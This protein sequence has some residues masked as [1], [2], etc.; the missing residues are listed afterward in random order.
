MWDV[1]TTHNHV[2]P[3]NIDHSSSK[4]PEDMI[5]NIKSQLHIILKSDDPKTKLLQRVFKQIEN[6]NGKI[7]SV[8][9]LSWGL[10]NIV[11]SIKTATD[12]FVLKIWEELC[13]EKQ[14][15]WNTKS[16]ALF[17]KIYSTFH[18][19]NQDT[20]LMER[21]PGINGKEAAN[22]ITNWIDIWVQMGT[23]LHQLHKNTIPEK[24]LEKKVVI[25]SLI[26]YVT[27]GNKQSDLDSLNVLLEH[28]DASIVNLHGDFSPHNCLFEKI[29]NWIYRVS[30]IFDPSWR[31]EK[32]PA[33]FDIFYALNNRWVRDK[34]AFRIGFIQ[35]YGD[36][37]FDSVEYRA[38][39]EVFSNYLKALYTSLES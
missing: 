30:A 12:D 28:G 8:T 21:K 33:I 14:F 16:I 4:L 35:W 20:I 36:I 11:Y 25:E 7:I 13:R 37:N 6:I 39:S 9:L 3:E 19:N 34:D 32:W 31:I 17:P 15:Y 29:N 18:A 27:Y 23:V 2:S 10:T 26:A 22:K 38:L 5:Q 24:Q 1:N